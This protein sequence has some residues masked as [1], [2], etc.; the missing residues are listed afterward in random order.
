MKYQWRYKGGN[1]WVD[2]SLPGIYMPAFDTL[3]A[4]YAEFDTPE[5]VYCVRRIPDE[6]D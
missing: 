2:M 6:E 3:N 1:D 5:G 4:D